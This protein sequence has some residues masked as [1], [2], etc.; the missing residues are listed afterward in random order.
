MEARTL[1]KA[2]TLPP[3]PND[4][5]EWGVILHRRLQCADEAADACELLAHVLWY[6]PPNHDDSERLGALRVAEAV[7]ALG[8]AFATDAADAALVGELRYGFVRPESDLVIVWAAKSDVIT[9]RSRAL[10]AYDRF[11]LFRGS[12]NDL[13]DFEG[14]AELARKRRARRKQGEAFEEAGDD[15]VETVRASLQ[16]DFEP[17]QTEG[18]APF[19]DAPRPGD[20]SLKTEARKEIERLAAVVKSVDGVAACLVLVNGFAAARTL[21]S[22]ESTILEA[23]LR[24]VG[25]AIVEK[26]RAPDGS[27]A[28]AGAGFVAPSFEL[29]ACGT[30]ARF[31]C[32]GDDEN[33]VDDLGPGDAVADVWC[34]SVTLP[35]PSSRVR[36]AYDNATGAPSSHEKRR[37]VVFY[38]ARHRVLVGVVIDDSC[39]RA[40]DGGLSR[41]WATALVQRVGD[42]VQAELCDPDR[43]WDLAPAPPSLPPAGVRVCSFEDAAPRTA[44]VFRCPAAARSVIADGHAAL[45]A[46][47]DAREEVLVFPSDHSGVVAAADGGARRAYAWLSPC[48][49]VRECAQRVDELRSGSEAFL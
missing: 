5:L 11:V 32:V 31:R 49:S 15:P 13:I 3:P 4:W 28:G 29:S 16:E 24:D 17:P 14:A 9:I 7:L 36:C 26:S 48:G 30:N 6:H 8:N 46:S 23:A 34:P 10:Q 27:W 22:N 38:A 21:P 20:A 19:A 25:D 45:V 42:A 43:E 33:D 47:A 1:L 18:F 41:R 40:S 2:K 39:V 35:P 44:P 37:L 12:I